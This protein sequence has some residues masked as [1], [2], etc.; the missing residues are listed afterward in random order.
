MG[1]TTRS[2]NG[3]RCQSPQYQ[4]AASSPLTDRD[5]D[6]LAS[7]A[8]AY[9]DAWLGNSCASSFAGTFPGTAGTAGTAGV[10]VL[11]HSAAAA[12][13]PFDWGEELFDWENMDS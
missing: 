5:D 13:A 8:L 6:S 10:P 12:A 7:S 2:S 4:S 9:D 11:S 1:G 3:G